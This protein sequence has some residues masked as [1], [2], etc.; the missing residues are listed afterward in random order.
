MGHFL[1]IFSP[2]KVVRQKQE[3]ELDFWKRRL[4]E[5]ILYAFALVLSIIV[6]PSVVG[7]M[8]AG[9]YFVAGFDVVVYSLL[10]FFY[11][12]QSLPVTIRFRALTTLMF[13][14]GVAML[15]AIG[16]YG[17]GFIWLLGYTTFSTIFFGRKG[18]IRSL[19]LVSSVL[20]FVAIINY[21]QFFPNLLLSEY[22]T[23]AF[24]LT[25]LNFLG[26]TL[27]VNVSFNFLIDRLEKNFLKQKN[28]AEMFKEKSH[29]LEKSNTEL[30]SLVYSL[31]HDI[32]SPLA[33]IV[34]LAEIG[35]EETEEEELKSYFKN[36]TKSAYKLQDFTE[37]V[38]TFFKVEKGK[39]K[40]IDTKLKTFV[41]D[42]F[43]KNYK[44]LLG[45]NG[46]YQSHIPETLTAEVDLT[47]LTLILMNIFSNATKYQSDKRPLKIEVRGKAENGNIVLS[48]EDNGVGIAEEKQPSIFEMFVRAN[49]KSTGAGLGLYIVKQ[50]AESI[51][52]SVS[53]ESEEGKFTRFY[54]TFP[55]NY[56]EPKEDAEKAYSLV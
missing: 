18:N 25:S 51:N 47:R 17:A 48:F 41:D 46:S 10:L 38:T 37:Q 32:R 21:F 28:I 23:L 12:R 34:G 29:L 40:P 13:L 7:A 14:T 1:S 20:V 16:P 33:N 50:S 24:S 39:I 15:F 9:L 42:V 2:P 6:V 22:D 49:E 3:S 43:L 5:Q 27:V 19:V 53:I 4:L 55:K 36:I 52:G 44:E 30:D 11:F 54:L 45:P 8:F 26:L 56:E 31:S 35:S